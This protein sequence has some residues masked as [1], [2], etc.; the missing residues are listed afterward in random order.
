MSSE[1]IARFMMIIRLREISSARKSLIT[2]LLLLLTIPVLAKELPDSI[3]GRWEVT[4]VHTNTEAS[5]TPLYAWNDP[6][7]VGR[8][9]AF[10][11]D[12]ISNDSPENENCLSP[13]LKIIYV[14]PYELIRKSMA[15]YGYPAMQA[16]ARAYRLS[17][18]RDGSVKTMRIYCKGTIWN[19]G[20]GA[21]GGEQG[22]WVVLLDTN[23]ILLRW[24][25]ET[26]LALARISDD[27]KPKPSFDCHKAIT[28]TEVEICRSIELSNFDRSVSELYKL[29]VAQYLNA[30][31]DPNLIKQ[32]QLHWI[33]ARNKC[34]ANR[35]C[36]L[37]SMRKRLDALSEPIR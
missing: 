4:E 14:D 22:S 33:S 32:D 34:S 25:D 35:E 11:R 15:G 31:K 13:Q 7:L 28:Q 19:G 18:G 20:L 2:L 6:R 10:S 16:S 1:I 30:D 27:Q 21:D 29:T 8:V 12:Q 37:T 3:E 24:Y 23:H 17:F 36:I 26:I 5:R 9:F